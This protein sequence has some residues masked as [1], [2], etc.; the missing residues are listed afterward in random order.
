MQN[1]GIPI[2]V[3]E[4]PR[5]VPGDVVVHLGKVL[6]PSALDHPLLIPSNP[7]CAVL[8]ETKKLVVPSAR[9]K[10]PGNSFNQVSSPY[11]TSFPVPLAF[12]CASHVSCDAKLELSSPS[13]RL[14]TTSRKEGIEPVVIALSR[15]I[16]TVG[17]V[18]CAVKGRAAPS[19]MSLGPSV[20]AA[21]AGEEGKG[22]P[23]I[24]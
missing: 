5:D 1:H 13:S 21:V 6:L 22:R 20:C 9:S 14:S 10:V 16:V 12:I 18:A 2:V 8:T 24:A 3:L 17:E 11:I 19:R 23:T 15:G 7:R 4:L